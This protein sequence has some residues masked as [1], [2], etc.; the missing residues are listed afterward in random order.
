MGGGGGHLGKTSARGG[1]SP[2][3]T[4]SPIARSGS[5]REASTATPRATRARDGVVDVRERGD[6][7]SRDVRARI[8]TRSAVA[9]AHFARTHDV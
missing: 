9:G 1:S 2:K 7:A 8:S 5:G 6:R 4:P 3:K